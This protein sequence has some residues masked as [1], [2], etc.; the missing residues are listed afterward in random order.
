VIREGE[1]NNPLI[2]TNGHE[3]GREHITNYELRKRLCSLREYSTDV[4]VGQ[5]CGGI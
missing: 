5:Y 4:R 1:K 2:F 3:Y